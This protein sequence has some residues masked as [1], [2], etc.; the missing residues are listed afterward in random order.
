RSSMICSRIVQGLPPTC[1]AI[2]PPPKVAPPQVAPPTQQTAACPG[3]AAQERGVNE[4]AGAGERGDR[5]RRPLVA[6]R[7]TCRARAVAPFWRGG[8]DAGAG[9]GPEW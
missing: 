4:A 3:G 5:P 6:S 9:N 8:P 7:A 1:T 2:V